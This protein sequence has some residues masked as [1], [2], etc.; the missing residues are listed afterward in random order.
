MT[1]T[2]SVLEL[3]N[4]AASASAGLVDHMNPAPVP[5]TYTWCKNDKCDET[6]VKRGEKCRK[7][8]EVAK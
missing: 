8:Q 1:F 5:S 3:V 4:A 6:S 2:K 7:C